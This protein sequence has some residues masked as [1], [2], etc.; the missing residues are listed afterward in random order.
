MASMNW[1]RM[2]ESRQD[3][4]AIE[5]GVDEVR[6]DDVDDPVATA[7]RNG[8][9]R[10]VVGER[11]EAAPLSAGEDHHEDLVRIEVVVVVRWIHGAGTAT[12]LESQARPRD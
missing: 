4:D 3:L 2:G 11:G 8:G 6:E 9:L 5:A 1:S 10:S 7:E 12:I